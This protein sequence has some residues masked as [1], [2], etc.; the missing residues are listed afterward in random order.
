MYENAGRHSP[1]FETGQQKS[2]GRRPND[3]CEHDMIACRGSERTRFVTLKSA[4]QFSNVIEVV[5]RSV[6]YF[7]NGLPIHKTRQIR[8]RMILDARNERSLELEHPG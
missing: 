5:A 7:G 8:A 6:S 3:A 2:V 4:I 1:F